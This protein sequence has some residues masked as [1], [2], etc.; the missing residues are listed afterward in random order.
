MPY[1]SS[2][3]QL[4]INRYKIVSSTNNT[5]VCVRAMLSGT[6]SISRFD[7]DGRIKEL[8]MLGGK[9]K[10]R[11]PLT[12]SSVTEV[13]TPRSSS[14]EEVYI[15]SIVEVINKYLKSINVNSNASKNK[16][17]AILIK[18]LSNNVSGFYNRLMLP[19]KYQ[20]QL[21]CIFSNL[22]IASE[23]CI[24]RFKE[25]IE[26]EE[27]LLNKLPA[28]F[29]YKPLIASGVYDEYLKNFD[30]ET[31]NKSSEEIDEFMNMVS[32]ITEDG[33]NIEI[34]I[35]L[36]SNINLDEL[37]IINS[38]P[39]IIESFGWRK[40]L[41]ARTDKFIASKFSGLTDKKIKDNLHK[42]IAGFRATYIRLTTSVFSDTYRSMFGMSSTTYKENK[43][44][45]ITEICNYSSSDEFEQFK[46]LLLE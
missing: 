12:D 31:M 15:E 37:S 27:Y 30:C 33:D 4:F 26:T 25:A 39:D 23:V 11:S 24:E 7:M 3:L 38:I 46:K 22:I 29:E 36:D 6:V 44:K 20:D 28:R 14:D 45:V 9:S 19:K 43:S 2:K 18:L 1:N 35:D 41:E 5:E 16:I 21:N 40:T 8:L 34:E 42:I 10:A 13:T 32:E 17:N